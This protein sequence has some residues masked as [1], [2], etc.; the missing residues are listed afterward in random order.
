[1]FPIKINIQCNVLPS[2]TFDESILRKI[3]N[4]N[5]SNKSLLGE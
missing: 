4:I 5:I 3:L 2:S 1:M